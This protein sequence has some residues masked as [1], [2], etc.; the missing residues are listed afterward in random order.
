M[1]GLKGQSSTFDIGAPLISNMKN[2]SSKGAVNLGL[3]NDFFWST[4]T[5]GFALNDTRGN[6]AYS[7]TSP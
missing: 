5:Q 6:Q 2:S 4:S 3:Y 1:R 7:F